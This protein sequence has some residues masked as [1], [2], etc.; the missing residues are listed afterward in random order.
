MIASWNG[1]LLKVTARRLAG[2]TPLAPSAAQRLADLVEIT[3]PRFV[4]LEGCVIRDRPGADDA[5]RE[6]R[7]LHREQPWRIEQVMNHI[8]L[9][10]LVDDDF[11]QSELPI[12]ESAA[13]RIADAWH[14][15]LAAQ[16][17]ERTFVIT[18]SSEP[19]DYGPTI[20]CHQVP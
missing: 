6:W 1:C 12:L 17:P 18:T 11:D 2:V 5:F 20:T 16:F 15:A 10:D 7:E 8:H 4:L 19:D 3:W 9:Y 13:H 14:T